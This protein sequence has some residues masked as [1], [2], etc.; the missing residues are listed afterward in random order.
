M[1][2]YLIKQ[3]MSG[4]F[5]DSEIQNLFSKINIET[6]E[7]SDERKTALTRIMISYP[8]L[9]DIVRNNE[10][11]FNYIA[12]FV[13]SKPSHIGLY[14]LFYPRSGKTVYQFFKDNKHLQKTAYIAKIFDAV[15]D[16][17]DFDMFEFM[18][19]MAT[20]I[21]G[22]NGYDIADVY[23]D[24]LKRHLADLTVE[25]IDKIM[26][27]YNANYQCTR[28]SIHNDDMSVVEKY[29]EQNRN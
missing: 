6:I 8:V 24:F 14:K 26:Q 23:M 12:T 10:E 7:L 3:G 11:A 5:I 21:P 9:M 16:S 20:N 19:I 22:Y 27:I 25:E 28:R 1:T 29:L 18:R 17:D 2:N 4:I 15:E 13:F